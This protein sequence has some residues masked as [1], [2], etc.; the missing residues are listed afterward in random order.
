VEAKVEAKKERRKREE[1]AKATT[2]AKREKEALEI[3]KSKGVN[4]DKRTSKWEV[5]FYLDGEKRHLGYYDDHVEA[6]A[7]YSSSQL[8]NRQ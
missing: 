7:V 4:W 1:D 5:A 2:R 3:P 8:A 6:V